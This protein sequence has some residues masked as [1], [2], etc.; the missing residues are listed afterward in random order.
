MACRKRQSE[1]VQLLI[2]VGA[3]FELADRGGT[4][5]LQVLK[6][7]KKDDLVK[8]CEH[9]RRLQSKAKIHGAG[10]TLEKRGSNDIESISGQDSDENGT[11]V[12]SI[13]VGESEAMQEEK[14]SIPDCSLP[15]IHEPTE[16]GPESKSSP[17]NALIEDQNH[18]VATVK[19]EKPDEVRIVN[20]AREIRYDA[21]KIDWKEMRMESR[22]LDSM[23]SMLARSDNGR[24]A[25]SRVT[26]TRTMSFAPSRKNS[27]EPQR[28]TLSSA[29]ELVEDETKGEAN[30]IEEIP[31]ECSNEVVQ[32]EQTQIDSGDEKKGVRQS[33]MQQAIASVFTG[34]EEVKAGMAIDD[35]DGTNHSTTAV[36]DAALIYTATIT[37]H[38]EASSDDRG[39]KVSPVKPKHRRKER[40]P[41]KAKEKPKLQDTASTAAVHDDDT[42]EFPYFRFSLLKDRQ[43]EREKVILFN[44]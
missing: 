2:N 44:L 30:S 31:H 1:V 29:N 25:S 15:Q 32:G 28:G 6:R 14:A 7:D 34:E 17:T 5:A 22:E 21:P 9:T 16:C 33:L 35:A 13:D 8:L 18:E 38:G 20:D 19:G 27:L 36:T 39:K 37:A 42:D 12:L 3:D 40:S 43:H 26:L 10:V 41:R 24:N 4:T 11:N 23:N